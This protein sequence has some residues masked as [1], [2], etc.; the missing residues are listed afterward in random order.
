[1]L[2]FDG[3]EGGAHATFDYLHVPDPPLPAAHGELHEI[4]GALAQVFPPL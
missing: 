2:I 4:L 1:V 3:S